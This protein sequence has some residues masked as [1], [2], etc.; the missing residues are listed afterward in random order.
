MRF[1]DPDGKQLTDYRNDKGELFY[2]TDDE[3][4]DV[5]IVSDAQVPKLEKALQKAEDNGTIN[6]AKT[7]KQEM[8]V[9]GQ[10]L[11][12]YTASPTKGTGDSWAFGY[13]ETYP[14]AYTE[15]IGHFSLGQLASSAV[16]GT[17]FGKSPVVLCPG[18]GFMA[19]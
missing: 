19:T 2:H 11:Q 15:G 9:L 13:K 12:K 10:T 7:N 4:K 16:A 5:I 14:E 3:L 17:G 18:V 6:D 1:I 8:H